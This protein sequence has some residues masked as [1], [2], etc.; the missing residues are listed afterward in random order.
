MEIKV[1]L[2]ASENFKDLVRIQ[3]SVLNII[4]SVIMNTQKDEREE[5]T[6]EALVSFNVMSHTEGDD[7]IKEV[8]KNYDLDFNHLTKD[9]SYIEHTNQLD[10]NVIVMFLD[11]T[12]EEEG[13]L[14]TIAFAI[15]SAIEIYIVTQPPDFLRGNIQ[16][17][18]ASTVN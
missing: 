7:R 6:V 18:D 16:A 1:L 14:E 15:R 17:Y 10:P 12:Y 9:K 5:N 2:L 3:S 11:P 8:L 13:I 4:E